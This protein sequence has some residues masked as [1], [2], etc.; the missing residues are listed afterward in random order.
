MLAE[1][2]TLEI[3]GEVP[4]LGRMSASCV[5]VDRLDILI[6]KG[7]SAKVVKTASLYFEYRLNTTNCFIEFG[8]SA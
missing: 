1:I 4:A 3:R 6:T 5:V 8:P 2:V 7:D